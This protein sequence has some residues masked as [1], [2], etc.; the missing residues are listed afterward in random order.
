MVGFGIFSALCGFAPS[1]GVLV[2]F[3]ILQGLCGGPLMPLS[4]TLLL[5]IF[6]KE[7]AAPATGAVGHDHAGRA[8]HRPDPGRLAVR[9]LS[10]GRW[11]F[12][13]NVP[14]ALAVCPFALAHA[15]APRDPDSRSRRSTRRPGLLVVWVGALQIML[16]LGKEHD[17]FASP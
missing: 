12:F 4:Q 1:F 9:Q 15:Q 7:K 8:D 5:R 10:A 16:D 2:S 13:I 17:W 3:R 11:I 6:P 14:V